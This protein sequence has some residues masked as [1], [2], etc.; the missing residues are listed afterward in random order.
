MGYPKGIPLPP[1][2]GGRGGSLC[3]AKVVGTVYASDRNQITDY[4]IGWREVG[5][6]FLHPE[7]LPHT[8]ELAL[9]PLANRRLLA[10][11][12]H[13]RAQVATPLVQLS[14]SQLRPHGTRTEPVD[15][16]VCVG[17]E[18]DELVAGR[19]EGNRVSVHVG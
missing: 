9:D 12:D 6:L 16:L 2:R 17:D 13:L 1:P 8:A 18:T 5:P 11:G 3:R 15:L 10:V 14:V 19:S 4:P 7:L